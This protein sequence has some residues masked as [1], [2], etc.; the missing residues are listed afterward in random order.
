MY[1]AIFRLLRQASEGRPLAE[2]AVLCWSS[3]VKPLMAVALGLL[4]ARAL[5]GPKP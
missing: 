4:Q 3:S 1:C 2:E 5:E